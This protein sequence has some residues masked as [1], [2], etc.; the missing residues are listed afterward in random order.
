MVGCLFGTST[1]P[2]LQ[3]CCPPA[4]KFQLSQPIHF[5]ITISISQPIILTVSLLTADFHPHRLIISPSNQTYRFVQ[6][7]THKFENLCIEDPDLSSDTKTGSTISGM[8]NDDGLKSDEHKQNDSCRIM[9]EAAT[10]SASTVLV[11]DTIYAYNDILRVEDISLHS[12]ESLKERLWVLMNKSELTSAEITVRYT[13]K[14]SR[15]AVDVQNHGKL[16]IFTLPSIESDSDAPNLDSI[17][18]IT[19]QIKN[20][21]EIAEYQVDVLKSS[22]QPSKSNDDAAIEKS[23]NSDNTVNNYELH[24][25]SLYTFASEG[26]PL[27]LLA[28]MASLLSVPDVDGCK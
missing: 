21:D 17:D 18:H 9:L 28:S 1:L 15:Q 6:S 19:I 11:S 22:T 26:D 5:A 25:R 2:T 10:S 8:E 13:E 20:D 24:L 27:A 12:V 4:R 3:F 7:T 23:G 16:I 14:Y